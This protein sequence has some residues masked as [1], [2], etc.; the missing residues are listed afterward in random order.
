MFA[1]H[2]NLISNAI[3]DHKIFLKNILKTFQLK[4]DSRALLYVKDRKAYLHIFSI[5]FRLKII[6][7]YY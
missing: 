2:S 5:V 4:L 7:K 6:I 3:L 1:C